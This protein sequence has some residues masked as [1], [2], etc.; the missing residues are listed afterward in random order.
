MTVNSPV[1]KRFTGVDH[2]A[3]PDGLRLQ[4][5]PDLTALPSCQKNQSAAFITSRGELVVWEDDPEVL[6]DRVAKLEQQ[7]LSII[8]NGDI[9]D[10]NIEFMDEKKG[11]INVNVAEVGGDD[12]S[13]LDVEANENASTPKRRRLFLAYPIVSGFAVML[14]IGSMG[15]SWGEVARETRLDGN[16][17]RCAFALMFPFVAWASLVSLPH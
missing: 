13:N 12:E 15:G 6:I 7:M 9:I 11:G 14:S 10:S 3:L 4:V 5:L 2:I 16:Y 17:M 8:W 1:I